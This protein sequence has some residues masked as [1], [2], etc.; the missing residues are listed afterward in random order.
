MKTK[1]VTKQ[2]KQARKAWT[3]NDDLKD[4]FEVV[5]L[6]DFDVIDELA[7]CDVLMAEDE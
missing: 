2:R 4:N 3:V 7:L 1:Q 5:M 6:D